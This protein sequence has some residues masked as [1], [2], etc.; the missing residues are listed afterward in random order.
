MDPLDSNQTA[1]HLAAVTGEKLSVTTDR[2]LGV[3]S[4]FPVTSS[5][6]L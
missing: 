3:E 5:H 1:I 4:L 6:C 2:R